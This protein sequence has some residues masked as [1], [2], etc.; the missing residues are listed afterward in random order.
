MQWHADPV[1]DASAAGP[2]D[3]QKAGLWP[4]TAPMA[5]RRPHPARPPPLLLD[6]PHGLC[7][8][9]LPLLAPLP[10]RRRSEVEMV[11]DQ[12]RSLL[13]QSVGFLLAGALLVGG[14][15]ASAIWLT[16]KTYRLSD[17]IVTERGI[18]RSA[19]D[20]LTALLDAETSYRG[21]VISGDPA[22]LDPYADAAGRIPAYLR[23][24]ESRLRERDGEAEAIAA[25][26]AAVE[27]KL[28]F[29]ERVNA[30]VREGRVD[31]AQAAVASG[32]G[33]A[34][35]DRARVILSPI[36]EESDTRIVPAVAAQRE[37]FGNLRLSVLGTSLALVG[38]VAGAIHV[39]AQRVRD[40][41]AA[42]LELEAL[43]ASLEE[44]VDQRTRDLIEANEEIQRFAYIVTHDLRAPLVNI[45]G[46]TSEVE[47]AVKPLQA[48]ILADG[49]PVAEQDIVDARRAAAEDLPEALAF[50]RA[51]ARKMD[52]LINAIL[53]I[54]REGRR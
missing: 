17:E 38:I 40:L 23:E 54:A 5:P 53:K 7:I 47:A 50:I 21:Y 51:S 6:N 15:A 29:T 14:L 2:V 3:L 37:A 10:C 46:F 33:R 39:V 32:E 48:Y 8:G 19:I 16:D 43:N 25:L 36:I 24:L 4:R 11:R 44:R 30:L 41:Q 52:G 26:A 22:F 18:R 49:A 13:R 42:R 31:E 34:M 9:L 27:D 28:A 20:L 1:G 45:M 12:S 35:M